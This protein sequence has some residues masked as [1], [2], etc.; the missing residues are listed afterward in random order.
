MGYGEKNRRKLE[1]QIN[2][3]KTH[4]ERVHLSFKAGKVVLTDSVSNKIRSAYDT[5]NDA[6]DNLDRKDKLFPIKKQELIELRRTVPKQ[7]AIPNALKEE[8]QEIINAILAKN[9]N[10]VNSQQ[11]IS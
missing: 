4:K 8:L 1:E 6:I 3:G 7:F 10:T 2:K 9:S 5:I 11:S